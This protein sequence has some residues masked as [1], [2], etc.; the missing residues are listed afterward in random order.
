MNAVHRIIDVD[1]IFTPI[2]PPN[3]ILD[4]HLRC[5]DPDVR[6]WYAHPSQ[7]RLPACLLSVH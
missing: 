2:L 4:F 5:K 1:N 6:L 3:H 7:S